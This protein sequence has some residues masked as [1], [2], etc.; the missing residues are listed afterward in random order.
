MT[1]PGEAASSAPFGETLPDGTRLW[2]VPADAAPT[3]MQRRLV[4]LVPCDRFEQDGLYVLH[5]AGRLCV[6][7][8]R[9]APE[10]HEI[11]ITCSATTTMVGR[12]HFDDLVVGRVIG[13][14]LLDGITSP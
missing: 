6:G 9:A 8:C 7:R 5:I 4:A 10:A 3:D 2:F 13:T 11:E 14:V 1:K 12:P